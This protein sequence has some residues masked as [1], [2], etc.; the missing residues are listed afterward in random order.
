[1]V[2]EILEKHVVIETILHTFRLEQSLRL[3]DGLFDI[4]VDAVVVSQDNRY[5]SNFDIF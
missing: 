4:L 2:V 5:R 3:L 1:M